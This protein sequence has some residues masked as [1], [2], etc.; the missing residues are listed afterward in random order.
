MIQ[1]T[2]QYA[3]LLKLTQPHHL[4]LLLRFA[5]IALGALHA[6]AA[7]ASHSMNADGI[8]YLDMGDAYFRGDWQMAVNGVWSP[9]YAWILGA[10]LYVIQPSLHWEFAVVHLVNFLIYL[11]A[12]GCFEFFWREVLR[13]RKQPGTDGERPLML[14]ENALTGLGYALFTI[15]SLQMIEIWSVTPDLLMSAW[16][17]L[18]AG[19]LLQ[20]RRGSATA[21]TFVRLGAVLALGYLSKAVMF[22]LAL[23]FL[24]TALLSLRPLRRSMVLTLPALLAFL[25]VAGPFIALLSA[26]QGK[27]TY[28]EAGPLV[29]ATKVNQITY[30]HW[31][32]D[33][34]GDGTPVHPSQKVWD[35]PPV[36]EIAGP[37]HCSYPVSYNPAYW[38]EGLEVRYQAEKQLQRL[39][40]SGWFYLKLFW[41]YFA[42]LTAGVALLFWLGRGKHGRWLDFFSQ[43]QLLIPP[44]AAFG[45]YALVLVESR[46]VGVFLVLLW[47]EL[48]SNIALPDSWRSRKLLPKISAMMIVFLLFNIAWFNLQGFLDLRHNGAAPVAEQSAPPASPREVAQT[49]HQLGVTPGADVGVIGYGFDAFWARLAR[50]HIVAEMFGW[51][52]Q[53]FWQGDT[54]LQ[55]GVIEAFRH[56]GARA[57]VA[58]RVRETAVPTGW[59]QVNQSNYFIYLMDE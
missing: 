48:L 42:G 56:S 45:L 53:P 2:K 37:F 10:A 17:Y 31:Q 13:S 49:L 41:L 26:R 44:L 38:Y 27:L 6:G 33:P 51:E 28:G 14:S 52:A 59:Q 11:A 8:S 15:A 32:G 7:I 40:A 5:V 29:Y 47:S 58:E 19:L 22:P 34:P 21:D 35:Q 3:T 18:A 50:V 30:P 9:L 39:A 24:G 54:A 20:I 57:I 1:R 55:A 25:L 46:Y 12:L 43:R 36:Y 16:V 23:V 4:R